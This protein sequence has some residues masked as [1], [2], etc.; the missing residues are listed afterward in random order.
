METN[1]YEMYQHLNDN[2]LLHLILS[3]DTNASFYLIG[4]KY[5]KQ[6]CGLIFKYFFQS[7]NISLLNDDLEYWLY[8]F[9]NY[10]DTP[11]KIAGKSQYAN[12][13]NKDDV[14]SWLYRCCRYFL[15]HFGRINSDISAVDWEIVDTDDKTDGSDTDSESEEYDKNL[16]KLKTAD[17]FYNFLSDRDIYIMYTYLYYQEKGISTVHLDEQIA[18]DLISCGYKDMTADHVRIIKNRSMEKAKKFFRKNLKK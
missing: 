7:F 2:E 4:V 13:K 17:Y 9:Q 8:S 6:L 3:G 10:I 16:L 18:N 1:D 15:Y 12:I 11:T 14:K 5:H